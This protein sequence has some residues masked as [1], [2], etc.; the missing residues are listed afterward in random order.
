MTLR[1]ATAAANAGARSPPRLLLR[2]GSGSSRPGGAPTSTTQ[3]PDAHREHPRAR[4]D[5]SRFSQ[6]QRPASHCSCRLSPGVE[7]EVR[8]PALPSLPASRP[9]AQEEGRLNFSRNPERPQEPREEG[10]YRMA[11]GPG[12]GG[13]SRDGAGGGRAAEEVVRRRC[14][15]GEEAEVSQPWS[16]GP[17]GMA[18]GPPVE[19][20]F[21]QMHLRKQVSYR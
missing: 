5:P 19:E 15:R 1:C 13:P 6:A 4:E 12:G 21:R 17:W 8:D 11:E 18:A 2:S 10:S 20:R 7:R 14:R 3:H 9:W 16:E